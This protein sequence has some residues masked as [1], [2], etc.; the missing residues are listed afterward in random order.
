MISKKF[1][2]GKLLLSVTGLLVTVRL[3]ST[4]TL[5]VVDLSRPVSSALFCVKLSTS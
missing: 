5:D 1:R 3:E 4:I 2:M